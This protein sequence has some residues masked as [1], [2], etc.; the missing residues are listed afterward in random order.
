MGATPSSPIPTR[1]PS[2][3][4]KTWGYSSPNDASMSHGLRGQG[5]PHYRQRGL[6]THGQGFDP[7]RVPM[8]A[9]DY[10]SGAGYGY[11]QGPDYTPVIPLEFQHLVPS[12]Q[13]QYSPVIPVLPSH[14]PNATQESHTPVIPWNLE[15]VANPQPH[16]PTP[17]PVVGEPLQH[18]NALVQ[19][20]RAASEKRSTRRRRKRRSLLLEVSVPDGSVE[21]IRI[22]AQAMQKLQPSTTDNPRESFPQDQRRHLSTE[23]QHTPPVA[24]IGGNPVLNNGHELLSTEDQPDNSSEDDDH[25]GRTF[26]RGN[27]PLASGSGRRINRV[28]TPYHRP[29]SLEPSINEHSPAP[30]LPTIPTLA[31]PGQFDSSHPHPLGTNQGSLRSNPLPAPPVDIFELPEWQHMRYLLEVPPKRDNVG[32]VNVPLGET[33]L[34]RSV[35]PIPQARKQKKG[36]FRVFSLKKSLAAPPPTRN[37][38]VRSQATPHRSTREAAVALLSRLAPYVVVN[39]TPRPHGTEPPGHQ[40]PQP[41]VTPQAPMPNPNAPPMPYSTLP[42]QPTYQIPVPNISVPAPHRP[43]PSSTVP[44]NRSPYPPPIVP[45]NHPSSFPSVQTQT[46]AQPEA[47]PPFPQPQ[48]HQPKRILFDVNSEYSYFLMHSPHP[49]IY[50]D[51]TY[52][53]AAHLLEALKFLPHH[54]EIAKRIRLTKEHRDVQAISAENAAL[55]DPAFTAAVVESIHK[56]VSLKFRQHADLRYNLC[57]LDDDTQIIYNDPLDSFWGIGFDGNGMNKL[58]MVLQR[59]MKELKPKRP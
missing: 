39:T 35:S 32:Q 5:Q 31:M 24:T 51:E 2:R 13:R 44:A 4:G 10:N 17:R 50:E 54:P 23:R 42:L 36:L 43:G 27:V 16:V 57:D 19:D 53:T 30:P 40:T 52:P 8:L 15:H 9:F 7:S 21:R 14:L 48:M 46:R 59:V 29:R 11:N 1:T 34:A 49:V 20:M 25:E 56:V 6:P 3:K 33:S 45:S 58:G 41:Q 37:A 22:G 47:R 26:Q 55:V 18:P 12:V 28:Q 38:S